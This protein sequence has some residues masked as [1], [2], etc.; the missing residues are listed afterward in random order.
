M[1]CHE[2]T[3]AEARILKRRAAGLPAFCSHTQNP[4]R[5]R[6]R[7]EILMRLYREGYLVRSVGKVLIASERALSLFSGT[8]EDGYAPHEDALIRELYSSLGPEPLAE[9][10]GRTS[11]AIKA[12]AGRISAPLRY[13]R[14]G[15]HRAQ[16]E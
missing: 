15:S 14:E 4:S 5:L 1:A 11:R 13:R 2:L 6:A 8:S 16:P 12:R 7:R 3:G 10:L 9:R